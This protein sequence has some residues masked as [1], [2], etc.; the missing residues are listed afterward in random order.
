MSRSTTI[1]VAGLW[2]LL[3]T[4][5]LGA[6]GPAGARTS[7][8][9]LGTGP[10][11]ADGVWS[12][13]Q[14]A[15]PIPSDRQQQ[16]AIYDPVGNRMILFGGAEYLDDT[17]SLT[18]GSAPQWVPL[19]P[20]GSPSGRKA[21]AMT[22]DPLRHRLIMFGGYDGS[23]QNDVWTLSLDG[24]P[25]WTRLNPTGTRPSGRM[26]TVA[27]YDPIA[28]R[29]IVFGGHPIELNDTWE[30]SLA[31]TPAWKQLSPSGPLPSPRYGHVG[32]FDPVGDRLVI[33]GGTNGGNEAWALELSG[34]PTWKRLALSGPQPAPR[35]YASAV[36]DSR[37][38]RMVV[39]GGYG[40]AARSPRPSTTPR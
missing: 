8:D 21:M 37:R 32:I 18:L 15:G 29:L 24:D 17:W 34:A 26:F 33:F 3:L 11:D 35:F 1:R 4:C 12:T 2:G 39:L 20:D 9:S 28:D 22:Y 38:Q 27:A 14:P 13:M 7:T 10:A 31:G 36:Y 30:L 40:V 5:G 19:A 23:Y 25:V 16:G 6:V